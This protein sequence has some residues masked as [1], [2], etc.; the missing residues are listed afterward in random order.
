MVV[1][2]TGHFLFDTKKMVVA[3][4]HVVMDSSTPIDVEDVSV[5]IC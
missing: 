4:K 2:D 3:F 1:I 5:N